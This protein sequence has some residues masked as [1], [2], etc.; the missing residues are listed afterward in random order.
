MHTLTFSV[1]NAAVDVFQDAMADG[2]AA[3]TARVDEKAAE[4]QIIAYFEQPPDR[5]ELTTRLAILADSMGIPAPAARIESVPK[6]DWLAHVYRG[7]HPLQLGRFYVYGSHSHQRP[8]AAALPILVDAATAF[9]SGHHATTASCLI[10]LSEVARAAAPRRMLDLGCGSGILAIGMAKLWRRPV[11]AMDID[12][13]A[14]RVTIENAHLNGCA[15]L[16][17]ADVGGT[18]AAPFRR[19]APYDLIM[20]NILARP[21]TLMAADIAAALAF[22]GTLILSGLLTAQET[23]VSNAYQA[24]GIRLV[25]AVRRDGWSALILRR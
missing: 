11:R 13:E 20:A 23:L 19:H 22:G 8:P 25:K 2:A 1:P 5:A 15:P 4:Q 14:V 17:R 21:L 6:T 12:P 10:A 16:I 3:I 7:L 9:G 18:D 24:H